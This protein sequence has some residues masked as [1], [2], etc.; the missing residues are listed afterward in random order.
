MQPFRALFIPW[1][2]TNSMATSRLGSSW[3]VGEHVGETA[4]PCTNPP[5]SRDFRPLMPATAGLT[6]RSLSHRA[7]DQA[8]RRSLR[9][10]R[11]LRR[12]SARRTRAKKPARLTPCP[13]AVPP[14]PRGVHGRG[15]TVEAKSARA[16]TT[17]VERRRSVIPPVDHV[18]SPVTGVAAIEDEVDPSAH[19]TRHQGE[20]SAPPQLPLAPTRSPGEC[21]SMR[22]PSRRRGPRLRPTSP[23]ASPAA[24]L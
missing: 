16:I 5:K 24:A 22:M 20:G 12:D 18:A 2:R 9:R 7:L 8:L 19:F 3:T 11:R 17:G 21:P 6:A 13:A 1:A 10:M 14:G 23:P 4:L 15:G